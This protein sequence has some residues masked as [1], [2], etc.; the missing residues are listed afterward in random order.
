MGDVWGRAQWGLE[1][2]RADLHQA[3]VSRTRP[4]LAGLRD[5]G[6]HTMREPE[7]SGMGGRAGS[8]RRFTIEVLD[9]PHHVRRENI[10]VGR[11]NGW[12]FAAQKSQP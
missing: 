1:H 5:R 7:R 11:K 10:R 6:A 3:L 9:H 4:R 2:L 12:Q 8:R